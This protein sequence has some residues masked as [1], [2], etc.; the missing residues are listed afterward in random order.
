RTA[1][2]TVT[3]IRP[4]ARMATKTRTRPTMSRVASKRL[5]ITRASPMMMTPKAPR[6]SQRRTAPDCVR[7][8]APPPRTQS[9]R[10]RNNSGKRM[11]NPPQVVARGEEE[12]AILSGLVTRHYELYGG[13]RLEQ[14]LVLVLGVAVGHAGEVVAHRP[15][16][17]ADAGAAGIA[18]RQQLRRA[19]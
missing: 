6:S 19:D 16:Q 2:S 8:G 9:S 4:V 10:G 15:L 12:T 18:L 13:I 5:K 14:P 3:T 1:R 7:A 11:G 17:V